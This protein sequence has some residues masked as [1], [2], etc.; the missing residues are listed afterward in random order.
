MNL[1]AQT[2]VVSRRAGKMTKLREVADG[3][4]GQGSQVDTA[5]PVGMPT[6]GSD[7]SPNGLADHQSGRSLSLQLPRDRRGSSDSHHAMPTGQAGRGVN[8]PTLGKKAG[9]VWACEYDPQVADAQAALSNG[10]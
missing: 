3:D 9:Y 2:R 5:G 10:R 4:G 8:L 1:E 6:P 7:G